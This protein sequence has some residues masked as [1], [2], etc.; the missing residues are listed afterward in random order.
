MR[1]AARKNNGGGARREQHDPDGRR[2][3]PERSDRRSRSLA[4]RRFVQTR[5]RITAMPWP[6]PMHIVHSAYRPPVRCS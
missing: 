1:A 4:R 5:S 3:T 2:L 6:T